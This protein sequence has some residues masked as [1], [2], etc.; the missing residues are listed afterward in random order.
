MSTT[1]DD[2]QNTD[3]IYESSRR[4]QWGSPPPAP[5]PPLDYPPLP[6]PLSAAPFYLPN[7]IAAIVASVGIVVGSI[8]LWASVQL[9]TGTATFGG[10]DFRGNWGLVTLILGV[11]SAIALFALVNWGRTTVSLRWAVPLAWAVLV[12]G[13]GSLA[14]ALVNIAFVTSV[15][16]FSEV[17][18]GINHLAQVG[19]G[20][21]LV[22]ICSGLL[23]VTAAI[24]AVQVGNASQ[25]HRLPSQA[26][27]AGAWR[28]AAII[29]SA[30]ILVCAIVNAYRPLMIG[31][32][33]SDQAT[34]TQ[35][36]TVAPSPSTST[37]VIAA[38]RIQPPT[39]SAPDA[40]VPPDA[41]HCSSNPVNVPL[42]NSAAGSD[43]TSCPFAEEVRD[44]YL[45]QGSRAATVTVNVF[46]PVTS[47]SYVITCTGNHVVI[48]TGGNNAVVYLY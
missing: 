3:F 35:T 6:Q 26:A 30:V 46:S 4:N 16:S 23:C 21:W 22:A 17:Y 33:S 31:N 18:F 36:V 48:C 43:V 45:R 14:I 27:W 32:G 24:V 5:P 44:Q 15:S 8:G 10:M 19:W 37:V 7:V 41:T 29:A 13:V 39:A 40:T 2:E 28:W 47:Q 38:P 42:D 9:P 1:N 25:D 12:G 34:A 11:V 20:L